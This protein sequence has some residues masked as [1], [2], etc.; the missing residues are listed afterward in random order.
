MMNLGRVFA[1]VS[2]ALDWNLILSHLAH[3]AAAYALA[4]PIAWERERAAR[5]AGLRTFP[6]V[7][8]ASCGFVLLA[9]GAMS[10]SAE[11]QSRVIQGVITGIGFLGGGAILKHGGSVHGMATAASIWNTGA[12]GVAIAYRRYEIALVLSLINLLTLRVM[13]PLKR[14]LKHDGES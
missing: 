6:L 2:P 13:T 3:V 8:I 1:A 4:L 7:A 10:H 14:E 9:A 12:I 11:A 5:S